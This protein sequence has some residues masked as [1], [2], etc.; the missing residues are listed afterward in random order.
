MF[1]NSL[2]ALPTTI[3]NLKKMENFFVH[4]LETSFVKL[5]LLCFALRWN[6]LSE[7]PTEVGLMPSLK[8]L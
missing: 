6:C 4:K 3:G 2:T 7:L 5:M 1:N 8:Y